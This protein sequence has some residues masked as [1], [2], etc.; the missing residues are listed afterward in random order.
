MLECTRLYSQHTTTTF[1]KQLL[2]YF[3]AQQ[4]QQQVYSGSFTAYTMFVDLSG[5]TKF[6][7]IMMQHGNEG[8]EELS[9]V[10]NNIFGPITKVVYAHGGFVPYYAGDALTGIFPAATT[11]V[12]DFMVAAEAIRHYFE[13]GSAQR[14]LYGDFDIHA[15]IGLAYGEVEWAI[16]GTANKGYYFKGR[17]IKGCTDSND[18]G[19]S[20]EVILEDTLL[21]HLTHPDIQ[22]QPVEGA[23]YRLVK[24]PYVPPATL[25]PV[26]LPEVPIEILSRFLPEYVLNFDARGEFRT[27]VSVFISFP[28]FDTDEQLQ[29][30]CSVVIELFGTFQGYFKEIDFGD[31]GGVIP[32]FFGAPVSFENNI[33]RA[34]EF[35]LALD[36]ALSEADLPTQHRVGMTFGLA[37]TGII[38]SDEREQY[39]AVGN[40]VNLA[41]RLMMQ[42]RPGQVL[43]GQNI[44]K[45]PQYRFSKTGD[46]RYKGIPKPVPTFLLEGRGKSARP[47]YSGRMIGRERELRQV[48]DFAQPLFEGRFAGLAYVYGEAG[49]GKSRFTYELRQ[50]LAERQQV[51]WYTCQADQILRKP[52]N[53]FI[54]FLNR[55]FRQSGEVSLEAN[56]RRFDY[57]YSTLIAYCEAQAAQHEVSDRIHYIAA[58][59][60]RTRFVLEALL[61]LRNDTLWQQLDAKGRYQ[62]T[63]AAFTNLLLAESL[64]RP[65]ILELEDIHW[66]DESSAFYVQDFTKNIG[67]FPILL[68]ATSR[69]ADDGSKP[70]L[71][72][73]VQ[74]TERGMHTTEVELE[75]LAPEAVRTFTERYLDGAVTEEFADLMVRAT[76]G[77][78]FYAEQILE[79]FLESE[80][81]LQEDGKWS[82]QDKTIELSESINAILTARIDRLSFM[83]RETVKAAAV[84]GREF[85][86]QILSEVMRAQEQ[87]PEGEAEVADILREQIDTAERSQIWRA[88]SELQYIFKH[89]LLREAVYNMQLHA[90]LRELHQ[91]IG[92]AIERLYADRLELRYADLAFHYEQ[93]Q[94]P[95]KTALYWKLAARYAAR[96][97]QHQQALVYYRNLIDYLTEIGE[98]RRALKGNLE[99]ADILQ[100]TGDWDECIDLLQTTLTEARRYGD[101][102]LLGRANNAFGR[103]MMLRGDYDQAQQYLEVA[104]ALFEETDHISGQYKALGNLGDVYFRQGQYEAAHD[105]YARSL[106]L[107]S[108]IDKQLSNSGVVSN[109]GL[110]FMNRG[111]YDEAI[112]HLLPQLA[113][114]EAAT[115]RRSITTL[116]INLGIVYY[117]MGKYERAMPHYRKG[118]EQSELLGD[119]MYT[120]IAVGCMGNIYQQQG[121]YSK[122]EELFERDLRLCEELGDK[123]GIAIALG[124]FADLKVAQ[125]EFGEARLYALRQRTMCEELQYQK[126]IANALM[127]LGEIAYYQLDFEE[128]LE[129]FDQ[130]IA[131][132]SSIDNRRV[133]LRA[134]LQKGRAQLRIHQPEP[135][136]ATAHRAIPIAEGLGNRQLRYEARLLEARTDYSVSASPESVDAL[137]KVLEDAT[138][139]AERAAAH[140]ALALTLVDAADDHREQ[141]I[142]LL[143]AQPD[144]PLVHM[145]LAQLVE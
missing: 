74:V 19:R 13:E 37:Y 122:A 140:Y 45:L 96:N 47:I 143:Q 72:S 15:K 39:A 142:S 90:R 18:V 98:T 25:P 52:F 103:L 136:Q 102:R 76:T 106:Q 67:D 55:Y 73:P 6:T 91:H 40:T 64:R 138:D 58:E 139:D 97:Y 7:N 35:V 53:A 130:S 82:V 92:E 63:L 125:S 70:L 141:A 8:A 118:L 61:G 11:D 62:N 81:L 69:Y 99:M 117:E 110:V 31:K 21:P 101:P 42:A 57:R 83:V 116:S 65:L 14:T 87:F 94:L 68:I 9:K 27:V 29:Q 10:L 84:I 41:A 3:I 77:N 80:L 86:I 100:L 54:Y 124:L 120:A 28:T 23:Y 59:L 43:V 105:Y 113:L 38:G 1:L 145:R 4:F 107:S 49:V 51:G 112:E 5:F 24:A 137:L 71:L 111:Q 127:T 93:A 133:L 85:D 44:A 17:A 135:A 108:S 123:Q 26:E 16:T 78:P 60:R 56:T 66:F 36:Q 20:G 88:I 114:S 128:A 75:L 33:E 121:D 95:E 50:V 144:H 129:L 30:F 48:L 89:S 104:A 34:L 109:L 79:Y 22:A 131:I 12:A 115:D 46:I 119:K 134:L 2:P 32:G 132:S 126:G